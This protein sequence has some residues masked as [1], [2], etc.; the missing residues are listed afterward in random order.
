MHALNLDPIKMKAF[1]RKLKEF[2]P[3]LE[4]LEILLCKIGR[5]IVYLAFYGRHNQFY[6]EIHCK[7]FLSYRQMH[8][9]AVSPHLLK[10]W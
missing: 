10:V 7:Q 9:S 1:L 6:K 3:T 4:V 8:F 5:K 2:S